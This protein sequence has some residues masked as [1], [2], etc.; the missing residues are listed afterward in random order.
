MTPEHCHN[1]LSEIIV[2]NRKEKLVKQRRYRKEVNRF[3]QNVLANTLVNIPNN[4]TLSLPIE[5]ITKYDQQLVSH[6]VD[7]LDAKKYTLVSP[8]EGAGRSTLVFVSHKDPQC[9]AEIYATLKSK[10]IEIAFL[11]GLLRLSPNLYNTKENI[12]RALTV[13]NAV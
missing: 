10:G 13:L 7:G 2:S 6:L 11:R 12:D 9:N 4:L 5:R 8:R 3:Y 1:G